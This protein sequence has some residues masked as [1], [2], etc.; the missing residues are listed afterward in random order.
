[1][2][3]ATAGT[4]VLMALFWLSLLA[5]TVFSHTVHGQDKKLCLSDAEYLDEQE[6]PVHQ[7]Y[8]CPQPGDPPDYIKVTTP[9]VHDS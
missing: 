6:L 8:V 5:L 7:Y 9:F 2:L 1:M 4:S 3:P